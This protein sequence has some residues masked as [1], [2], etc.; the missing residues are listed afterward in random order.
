MKVSTRTVSAVLLAGLC[1]S[2]LFPCSATAQQNKKNAKKGA[3]EQKAYADAPLHL[4]QPAYE[5]HYGPLTEESI[6]KDLDRVFDYLEQ[7]TPAK[8]VDRITGEE[9]TDYSKI[10]GNS[11]LKRGQYGLTGY[12]WGVTYSGML[13]TAEVTGD[14]RYA[15]YTYERVKLI[16]ES[17]PYFKKVF[18]ETGSTGLRATVNPQALDDG[19][20]VCAAMVKASLANPALK[21]SLRAAM[22]N[23]FNFVM[24]KEYRLPDGLLARIRPHRN[25]VWLD[26]MYMGIP[27]MAYMGKLS[28]T[29]RGD[30]TQKYY[31]EAVRQIK[32]FKERMWVPEKNLFRHGYVEAMSEH[33]AF[34][35]GRANG[36]AMLTMCDVLDALPENY[37]GREEIIDLLRLHIKGVAA[38]Q[39]GKGFWHQLLDRNDSYLETSATAIFTYCIAHAI[40]KGW[41]DAMAY[42]PVAQLGWEAVATQINEQGQVENTCVGT[43]MGFDPA[44]YYYR[45]VNVYAAHGYGP[46]LLAGAEMI[47]LIKNKYPRMN[48]SAVMYYNQDPHGKGA[49]FK[50]GGPQQ[51]AGESRQEG[52]PVVFLI[53]DSTCKNGRG[54]GD[55]GQWGWGSFFGEYIDSD[56]ATVE[57]HAV[58]GLSSRTFYTGGNW[59]NVLSGLRK[60]DF[61]IIQFGHN[62]GGSLNTGRAR[63][64]IK[65]SDDT[66]ER[67]VM[68]KDGSSQ[69]VYTFG[70]YIRMFVRQAKHRGAIPVVLSHTPANR[71]QGEKSI[72]RCTDTYAKWSKEVAEQEGVLY[73]DLNDLSAQE[74]EKMGKSAAQKEIFVDSVHTTEKGARMNCEALIKGL[75]AAGA[76][77]V[78]YAK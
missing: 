30:L 22:D 4:L 38:L 57:N 41:I 40:N 70:R 35:W 8:I 65:G 50:V 26:D 45:P 23:Y 74:C 60:G 75:K 15:D 52:K 59:A 32:L 69:D 78:E 14:S 62:D 12:E 73:I 66:V 19:G 53:G 37:A 55:G 13:R 3:T 67:V 36:W 42:G 68:E 1:G 49:I 21:P 46:T 18:E 72:A 9:I 39:S 27:V 56:K 10:D 17:Y 25:S 51:A 33:P 48:D 76:P 28:Q 31:S 61:V 43:G 2:L 11:I 6:K 54:T 16:G 44:F 7:T 47:A 64:S 71:W 24:Y 63:A 34:F 77:L 29:E 5:F 20:A 58:G